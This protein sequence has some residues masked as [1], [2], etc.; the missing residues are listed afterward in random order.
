LRESFDEVGQL[1]IRDRDQDQFAAL[2]NLQN[3]ENGN[4]GQQCLGSFT[5]V[6]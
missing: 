5:R 3:F 1:I 2:D 6:G 4:T